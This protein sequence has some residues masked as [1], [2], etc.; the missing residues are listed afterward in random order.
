[1]SAPN[2][3]RLDGP[4]ERG[5]TLVEASAGTGKTYGIASLFVR[6]V[7]E[8]AVPVDRI[9]VVTFTEAATLELRTRL[10]ARLDDA[11]ALLRGEA[12][13]DDPGLAALLAGCDEREREARS[14]RVEAAA[15]AFDR[16]A[17][18]TI[19]GFCQRM[20]ALHAFEAGVDLERELVTDVGPIL[21][22]LVADYVATRL[23][24]A[25]ALEVQLLGALGVDAARLRRLAGAV[26]ADPDAALTPGDDGTF[27]DGYARF[28]AALGAFEA[29]WRGGG[30]EACRD[31][32]TA[33]IDAAPRRLDGRRYRT[34]SA[35]ARVA[36]MDAFLAA[37]T[38]EAPDAE[39]GFAA[40]FSAER[41]RTFAKEG[42]PITHPA[43]EAWDVVRE[44]AAS[45]RGSLHVPRL[46]FATWAR[47]ELAA[48]LEARGLVGFDGLVRT[49]ARG[50]ERDGRDGA[51]ATAI[52]RRFDAALLD[53]FQDTDAAQWTIFSGIF[54][55][56]DRS[57]YLIGDPKQAIYGFRGA[58]VHVYARAAR[59]AGEARRKTMTV[60]HRSD[61]RYVEAMNAVFGARS[62]FFDLDFVE[63]VRVRAA[64]SHDE[65]GVR[66][67][68]G[69]APLRL[70]CFDGTARGSRERLLGKSDAE[71]MLPPLV[72]DDVLDALEHGEIRT[73]DGFRPLAPRD[74]AVLVRT[75]RQAREMH[76]ALARR[77]IP[78]VVGDSGSVYGTDEAELVE[79]C[80]VALLDGTREGASRAV[81]LSAIGGFSAA[82]LERALTTE[83]D[84]W[85]RFADDLA[86]ARRAFERGGVRRALAALVE[87][88]EALAR[89]AATPAGERALVNL[90][91]LG[92]LLHRAESEGRLGPDGVLAHLRACRRGELDDTDDAALRLES[93]E[94]TVRVVTL[95]KSKGLEYPVVFAS[96]LWDGAV[97][98]RSADGVLRFHDEEGRVRLDLASSRD[99]RRGDH[100]ARARREAMQ[101]SLR[102]AYVAL[103][104]ARH[105][106]VAYFGPVHGGS[107]N[108]SADGY[109]G[110]ALA[111][112]VHA[113]AVDADAPSLV[114]AVRARVAP[115][116]ARKAAPGA[117]EA[118]LDGDPAALV[119]RAGGLVDVSRCG[120]PG[121]RR[122]ERSSP[123]GVAL[124]RRTLARTLHES[125]WGRHSYTTLVRRAEEREA[126]DGADRGHGWDEVEG[127]LAAGEP[128]PPVV[129]PAGPL[130]AFPRGAAAGTFVHE[131]LE[132]IDFREGRHLATG[133][134]LGE[135]IRDAARASGE[136]DEAALDAL[137]HAL[138]KVL[139]TPLGPL[140][141]DRAL[142]DAAPDARLNEL[143]FDLPLRRDGGG[144][145]PASAIV[146]ALRRRVP[147]DRI[148]ARYLASLASLE[149]TSLA[150]FLTGTIDLVVRFA[151]DAGRPRYFVA[152]YKTND[153]AS[154]PPSR[155]APY[156]LSSMRGAMEDHHYFVQYHLYLVALHRLL[157]LRLGPAYDYD[158]DVG[159]AL[160]LFVRGMVGEDTP[161]DGAVVRGVFDDKPPREVID[162]L[163]ALFDEPE[164]AT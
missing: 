34:G 71:A 2:V 57:L 87:R 51:L 148:G 46:R 101:E 63:Y 144:A 119:A 151:G 43:L 22:E 77:G 29:L 113:H 40:Y 14:R 55:D 136:W 161:R 52:R 83:P 42:P 50:I 37:P 12:R 18:S 107:G 133:A 99:P 163:S 153:L 149:G 47:E 56:P 112:L 160:Y 30:R 48:R 134:A 158:R 44:A 147:D 75:N 127:A 145:V 128:A 76:A 65:D 69:R 59:G 109:E 111:C 60:N 103:T 3:F 26:T 98:R 129:A 116:L 104:R 141:G 41:L 114:A 139:A 91:H 8:S 17:I 72:A 142:R 140:A 96:H 25:P 164:V 39:T 106:A 11:R 135:V 6:L 81:A 5:I 82:S 31:A 159:G 86:Q 146:D 70:R 94:D 121:T 24:G 16:A 125:A 80:L 131:V 4:L 117:L 152:D 155:G 53:E 162:A 35:E 95:H 138:P 58:D 122:Y 130:D 73:R 28:V 79:R 23:H 156:T 64:P 115:A 110:S 19:H 74:V 120:P 49:L 126:L 32:I 9:L 93:D 68:D 7:A 33:A 105:M 108:E 154:G 1:M 84:R 137:E 78:A 88:P 15:L 21:D 54:D 10:R 13:G 132:R 38:L 89:L 97:L 90:R 61:A 102:L 143:A 123:D 36:D 118:V 100:E 157:R 124:E 45:L 66:F 62:G 67:A 20:L 92:E 150:G 27:D 85:S